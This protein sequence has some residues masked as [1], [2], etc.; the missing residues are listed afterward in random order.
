MK[1][2]TR[3][4]VLIADDDAGVRRTLELILT[5]KGF[6][7][8][9]AATAEE[10][11]RAADEGP[12]NVA[13]L[14]IRLPDR[15]GVEL[16]APLRERHPEIGQ[17]LI[18]GYASTQT[19]VQALN[20]GAQAY[21][22][23]PV[24]VDALLAEVEDVL[25]RQR[26][27]AEKREAERR[28]R[29][30]EERYRSLFERVPIALYRT[31]PCGRIVDV[32]PALVEM[33]GYPDR[34]TVL[35]TDVEDGFLDSRLR[36]RWQSL[37]EEQG[38]VRRFEVQYKRYDG[39]TIWVLDSARAVRDEDGRIAYYEGSLED[40]TERKRAER[41]LQERVKELRCLYAVQRDVQDLGLDPSELA[42]R[43]I[44]HMVPSL[45]FPD[46]VVP[47]IVIRGQRFS[48][49]H[50]S[51]EMRARASDGLRAPIVV[52]EEEVG[53]VS[54]AYVEDRPFL[55]PQEQSL[56]DSIAESIGLWFERREA[57][58]ALR[59]SE[60]RYRTL[61]NSA[62]DA[63]FIHDM[64]GNFL[65]V[66]D[67]ACQRLGYSRQELLEMGPR[68]LDAKEYAKK[69]ERRMRTLRESGELY[70]E[71]VHRRKNGT[72][73]PTE[74]SARVVDYS[75][76]R[77]VLTI[78]RDVTEREDLERRLR[79]QERLATLG[80]LAGGLAHDTNNALMSIMLCGELL[81]RSPA[82]PEEL[83]EDVE[84]ILYEAEEAAA[85]M[86]Q[87]LD[88]S[89]KAPLEIRAIEL[90]TVIEESLHVLRRVI[91]ESI[92]I[93]WNAPEG[94]HVLQA[95]P[96]RIHQVIMN[97]AINARDAMPGGGE[98][99]IDLSCLSV[100][101]GDRPPVAGMESGEW[102]SLEVEDTGTGISDDALEH[103]FEP[104]FTTKG[105]GDGTGLGLAQVYGIVEQHGGHISVQT[106]V[107][108][109]SCFRIY[110]PAFAGPL[111]G[112]RTKA[113][114][115]AALRGHGETVLVVEDEH[116]VREACRRALEELDYQVILAA[117][118]EEA[119][120]IL[121]GDEPV[122]LVLT[123]IVMPKLDGLQL[124]RRLRSLL[125]GLPVVAMT[126]Y[127]LDDRVVEIREQ[128]YVPFLHKP[129]DR[130]SLAEIVHV[131]LRL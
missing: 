39:E 75:G 25:E 26:L 29:E 21:I 87:L 27:I 71:T 12:F 126:G 64:E 100:A 90:G 49:E 124:I 110:L 52:G 23:K 46:L 68:D 18:T 122:D 66:N 35:A 95:D 63:I 79:R 121:K 17:I 59:Q 82:L 48:A 14:D 105:P 32:N 74:L 43:I 131:A 73:I 129:V 1:P 55:L 69:F 67:A 30:S 81:E 50:L 47:E 62:N 84:T 8:V 22:T 108:S 19:A 58:K 114:S 128:E 28:L 31:T 77:A 107:G 80:Q 106:Q 20:E 33:L 76:G 4:Q 15:K 86:R 112:E 88:F 57:R 102:I 51:E 118:G 94:E 9:T 78:A 38:V 119:L 36:R 6:G 123:D 85:I 3:P 116:S 45:R 111:R 44:Q 61:F 37:M 97:L 92:E 96:S 83:T 65:E 40:I 42:A 93:I 89:R 7:V 53:H 72:S 54:A 16:L 115:D 101:P 60:A 99:R 120:S 113:G 41:A 70:A 5:R 104:F 10:A 125:P 2:E 24:D 13:L 103:L 91:P 98:L 34:E 11:L 109:G 56:L 130:D 117:D 127:V